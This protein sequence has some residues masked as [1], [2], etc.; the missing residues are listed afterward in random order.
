MNGQGKV[1][2][3]VNK[4]KSKKSKTYQASDSTGDYGKN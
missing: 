3:E 2:L 1:G 4:K